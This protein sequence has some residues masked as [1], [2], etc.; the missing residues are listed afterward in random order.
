MLK[1][2]QGNMYNFVTHM[3][4]HLGGKCSNECHYCLPE[5][6]LV[7]MGDY[8]E[9]PIEKIKMGEEIV[10][11]S[12]DKVTGYNKFVKAKVKATMNRKAE[13]IKITTDDGAIECTPDHLLMGSS[14]ARLSGGDWKQAKAFSPRQL[15]KF[16]GIKPNDTIQQRWIGCNPFEE[17]WLSGY[18]DGDGCF[19]KFRMNP[20]NKKKTGFGFEAVSIDSD[21]RETLKEYTLK[22]GIQLL[23]GF[24]SSGYGKK[25]HML[26]T[27][28]TE[29]AKRLEVISRFSKDRHFDFYRGYIAG[30][31]DAEGTILEYVRISQHKVNSKIRER[32]MF[33]LSKLTFKYVEEEFGIRITGG[34]K[35]RLRLL[36]ECLPRC[37]RKADR[38]IIGH[39]TKGCPKNIIT[40]ME[41]G[42]E[43]EV[44][45]L[46]TE[47]N[48]YIANGF[49]VHNC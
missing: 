42:R 19:F 32:I 26:F 24:K 18:I 30:I 28:K 49:K 33:S 14:K 10:G 15:L 17:G 35:M 39:S 22:S 43:T 41:I 7:L 21:I 36:H 38:L 44:Y 23:E 11:I 3:Q 47:C 37:K 31:I 16:V 40:A 12:Q 27:R 8:T 1:K 6:A 25:H 4:T 5:G 46:E 29:Q 34:M 20:E 9:K 48:N 45:N 2:A 13:T